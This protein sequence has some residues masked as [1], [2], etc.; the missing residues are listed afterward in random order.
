MGVDD[1]ACL[2][3]V[4]FVGYSYI[5]YTAGFINVTFV[6]TYAVTAVY[7]YTM[8]EISTRKFSLAIA[9]CALTASL[10]YCAPKL[11]IKRLNKRRIAP[12]V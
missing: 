11:L 12:V 5:N 1:R 4:S 7:D 6:G 3:W 8:G 10:L 2:S 9:G